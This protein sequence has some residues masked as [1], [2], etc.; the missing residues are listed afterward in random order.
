MN[1]RLICFLLLFLSC[2][3]WEYDKVES[4]SLLAYPETY[5]SLV[6]LDTI[7]DSIDST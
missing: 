5:L 1:A 2:S 4:D 6:A 3:R 7:Y